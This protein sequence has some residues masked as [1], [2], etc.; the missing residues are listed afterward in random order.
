AVRREARRGRRDVVAGQPPGTPAGHRGEPD[1]VVGDEGDLVAV[2]VGVSEIGPESGLG[3]PANVLA[4]SDTRHRKWV[5]RRTRCVR[6]VV[7]HRG[8]P[9]SRRHIV[10]FDES[11]RRCLANARRRTERTGGTTMVLPTEQT[12]LPSPV[13][14]TSPG[15]GRGTSALPVRLD[16]VARAF[17]AGRGSTPRTVLAGVDLEVAPGEIVAVLGPSGCG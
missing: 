2:D 9:W 8:T 12:A 3:H 6:I 13:P 11:H 16:G 5:P 7:S 15:G 1:V 14:T 10:R 4:A 17:P